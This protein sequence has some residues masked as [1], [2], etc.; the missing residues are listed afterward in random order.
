MNTHRCSIF[1][2]I[3]PHVLEH[4]AKH[5]EDEE[6]AWAV[7]MLGVD[8]SLRAAR[9]HNTAAFAATPVAL[10]TNVL[11]ATTDIKA[12]VTIYDAEHEQRITGPVLRAETHPQTDDVAAN[13]AFDG[14]TATFDFYWD[15]YKRN[16]IDDA[17]LPLVGIVHYGDRYPNAVWDGHEMIFG[18]GDGVRFDRFTISIDIMAHELTHGVTQSTA[19]LQYWEQSGALNES[20][21][22][23]FGSLVKQHHANET[24]DDADWLIGEHLVKAEGQ[25][26]RSLEAP[27]TAYDNPQLGKDP[28]P[29]H[30]DRYVQTVADHAGVH[31]NSGI[32]N[33][34]FYNVATAIA[35]TAT[36]D[37]FKYA[38]NGAGRIWYSALRDPRL[39]STDRFLAFAQATARSARRLFPHDDAFETAVREG[40]QQVGINL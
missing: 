18:D 21:S 24:V 26:L 17:G 3:P 15:V 25:A 13:E 19:Q 22:D 36:G 23:V 29:D 28:Q 27:G 16:S 10:R 39:Q 40:W 20:I 32:P 5:G 11:A 35:G 34:A 7:D 37:E 9:I 1:C 14:L 6:R 4:V 33:K 38:W 30:I 31:I 12:N 2:L 8:S